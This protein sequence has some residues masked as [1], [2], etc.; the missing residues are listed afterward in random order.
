[1]Y[2]SNYQ[3]ATT[4]RI[5][6]RNVQP[7]VGLLRVN[8]LIHVEASQ[9]F[10]GENEWRFS[11]INGW[12]VFYAWLNTVGPMHFRWL[13]QICLH[14][15][16]PGKDYV[17][18]P[19]CGTTDLVRALSY[20]VLQKGF[21]LTD[22]KAERI[23]A[24]EDPGQNVRSYKYEHKRVRQQLS[25]FRMRMQRFGFHVPR[26]WSYEHAISHSITLLSKHCTL[27]TFSLIHPPTYYI[28]LGLARTAWYWAQLSL[29]HDNLAL[30]SE[31]ACTRPTDW[32]WVFLKHSA[33]AYEEIDTSDILRVTLP[34][35]RR[36][37]GECRRIVQ[38][39]RASPELGRIV[40]GIN[41]DEKRGK[42]KVIERN[43]CERICGPKALEREERDEDDWVNF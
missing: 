19:I 2:N 30:N 33:A 7:L 23:C 35:L 28:F 43:E 40:Y 27:R 21:R 4:L 10:Y 41:I 18:F 25:R 16:L 42:Y 8:R 38:C 24:S 31:I 17:V 12:M 15:P 32:R 13:K 39:I 29:L 5:Y 22:C 6:K 3:R 11:G 9:I 1:M 20:L 37:T 34:W 36:Y 14:I 26:D